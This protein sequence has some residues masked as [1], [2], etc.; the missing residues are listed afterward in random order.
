MRKTFR[1]V[2]LLLLV[3][4]IGVSCNDKTKSYSD[5]LKNEKKIINSIIDE[6]DFKR[7]KNLKEA[8][9]KDTFYEM[10]NGVLINIVD[11]G[12]GLF[13]SIACNG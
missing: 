13:L 4:F 8:F 11:S 12:N 2:S 9:N 6:K 1:I 10:A 5:K 3:C 7:T